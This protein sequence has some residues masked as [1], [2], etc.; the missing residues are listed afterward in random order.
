VNVSTPDA[1]TSSATLNI[2]GIGNSS[3]ARL[4]P[5]LAINNRRV[6]RASE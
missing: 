1:Y 4:T 6:A 2:S 5:A 3:V